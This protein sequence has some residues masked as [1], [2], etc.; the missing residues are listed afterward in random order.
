MTGCSLIPMQKAGSEA[1]AEAVCAYEKKVDQN[2]TEFS[3][4]LTDQIR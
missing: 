2:S 3:K 4:C 1:L